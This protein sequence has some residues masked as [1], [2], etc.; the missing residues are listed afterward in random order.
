MNL[1]AEILAVGTE[2]LLGNIANTDAQDVSNALSELGINVFYHTVVGDNPQRVREAV[3]IAKKR[4][5]IIITTGGLG[6]TYD[7]LTKQTLAE[8]F[9]KELYFD[10]ESAQRIR[11]LFAKRLRGA[12]MTENNLQQ[13]YF[14][15]GCTVFENSCGT[16]PGCA[17]EADGVHVLML[18]GPPSECRAMIKTGLLPYLKKLSG[19]EIRSHNIRI[20]GMGESSVEDKLRHIM[21]KLDNPTLAPYAKE[22]EVLLRVTAKASNDD[23]ADVMMKPVIEQ[24]KETIGDF[25]YGIDVESLEETVNNLLRERGLTMAAAES[26]TGGL[27]SKRMTDIAGASQVFMGGAVTYA[28]SAKAGILCVAED[29]LEKFGAVSQECAIEMAR[30]AR[31]RFGADIAVSLTG[32]AGPDSDDR[33][34]PVGLVYIGFASADTS[35]CR[36]VF[37]GSPRTRCRTMAANY[38]LDTVRRHL[39]NIPMEDKF[40]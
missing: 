6:P 27:V 18:P 7:D 33:G 3:E 19:L 24:V 39:L 23:E 31:E 22:G 1:T 14:P 17:F 5:N 34:N 16:A 30:G 37:C 28:T 25:I 11:D 12:A 9:G 20:F 40:M 8:C 32:V 29:T 4:A 2:I 35:F 38:A 26:L 10:E 13:A 36:K 21:T 15:V